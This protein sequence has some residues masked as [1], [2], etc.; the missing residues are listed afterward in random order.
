VSESHSKETDTLHSQVSGNF[1]KGPIRDGVLI[2]PGP[3]VF[4]I[5]AEHQRPKFQRRLLEDAT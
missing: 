5:C 1:Y 2:V 3:K 4:A